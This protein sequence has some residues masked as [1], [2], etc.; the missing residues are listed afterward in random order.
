MV[1]NPLSMKQMLIKI[2]ALPPNVFDQIGITRFSI[3]MP[4]NIIPR[5]ARNNVTRATKSIAGSAC[6]VDTSCAS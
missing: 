4:N 6:L 1:N 2:R 3:A 5:P